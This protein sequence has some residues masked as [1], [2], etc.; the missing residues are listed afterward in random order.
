MRGTRWAPLSASGI[1]GLALAT[2][3]SEVSTGGS[4]AISRARQRSSRQ[5]RRPFSVG[6]TTSTCN[7]RPFHATLAQASGFRP[8]V[9]LALAPVSHWPL[10]SAD[11]RQQ[12]VGTPKDAV[13]HR[14]ASGPT[15]RP[16]RKKRGR[17]DGHHFPGT[18]GFWSLGY[19]GARIRPQLWT[20]M[21]I[22]RGL[23]AAHRDRDRSSKPE[24]E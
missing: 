16:Q 20:T 12:G 17:H 2:V 22:S 13:D 15:G 7:T 1:V 6:G 19:S 18:D 11:V 24:R 14:L 3:P 23:G 21:W 10:Y 9:E 4:D 8:H 5:G